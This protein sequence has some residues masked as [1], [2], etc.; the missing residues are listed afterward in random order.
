VRRPL[1]VLPTGAGKTVIFA[2]LIR[3][4]DEPALVLAHRDE[5]IAQADDKIG[6]VAPDLSRGVIKAERNEL[7]R[8][9]TIASVQTLAQPHRLAQLPRDFGIVVVDEAHHAPAETY[10]RILAALDAP[11]VLGVTATADRLDGRGLNSTFDEIVFDLSLLDLMA[12]GYLSEVRAKRVTYAADYSRLK[13]TAGDISE[14]SA[15]R[16]FREGGGPAAV[17]KALR[18]YAP[19]RKSL[20]FV[21]GV[22]CAHETAATATRAGIPAA[23]LDGSTPIKERRDILQRFKRGSIKALANCGV[24]T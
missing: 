10:Q 18:D 22:D 9:V 11:F 24:L 19:E 6:M 21:P 14:A 3:R 15:A 16:A 8:Q 20:I 2:E 12:G 17:A 23:A 13:V 5:L 4:I 1:L 7:G